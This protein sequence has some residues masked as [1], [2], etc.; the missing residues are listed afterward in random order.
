MN[1][2]RLADPSSMI[3]LLV[4]LA[5]ALASPMKSAAGMGDIS[6]TVTNRGSFDRTFEFKDGVA[7]RSWTQQIAAGASVTL[8]LRS[9]QSL[10]D[11]YGDI[12]WRAAGNT[13][14][15]HSAMLRNGEAVSL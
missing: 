12:Y 15:N 2:N 5:L 11:G 13:T 6:V 1:I 8:S 7:G 10:D 4:L 9:N 14:W 3:C